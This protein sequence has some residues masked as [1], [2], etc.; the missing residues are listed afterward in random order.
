[1]PYLMEAVR[2]HDTGIPPPTSTRPCSTFG[3]PMGPLRLLDEIGLDVAQ[4]VAETLSTAFP[5]RF[6]ASNT[7]AKKSPPG[8]LGKKT[9]QGFYPHPSQASIANANSRLYHAD[10]QRHLTHL[11]TAEAQR[12]LDENVAAS[13]AD[14]NLAMILGTGYPP[15]TG[16]PLKVA[17]AQLERCPLGTRPI[18]PR[19]LAPSSI[20]PAILS[21]SKTKG[22]KP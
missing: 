10:I 4:H 15:A 5:G 3:M 2:L 21:K 22:P 14:I 17:Q 12:C 1:M 20:N 6:T 16:G 18:A 8:T 19:P 7:C 11:L 13:A 9:G